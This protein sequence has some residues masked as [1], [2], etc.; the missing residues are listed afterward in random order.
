MDIEQSSEHNKLIRN[1][2]LT[3]T[4]NQDKICNIDQMCDIGKMNIGG[5]N[6]KELIINSNNN[7]VSRHNRSKK[8]KKNRQLLLTKVPKKLYF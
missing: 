4:I 6:I 3:L 2:D 8:T 1:T 7:Y 5:V